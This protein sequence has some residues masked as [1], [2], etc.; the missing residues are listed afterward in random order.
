MADF[1]AEFQERPDKAARPISPI[2]LALTEGRALTSIREITFG[3]FSS[4]SDQSSSSSEVNYCDENEVGKGKAY[5]S[6]DNA[7]SDSVIVK[8]NEFEGHT[9]HNVI[10]NVAN[11][12]DERLV[13]KNGTSSKPSKKEG[14]ALPEGDRNVGGNRARAVD[15]LSKDVVSVGGNDNFDGKIIVSIF[16]SNLKDNF[17]KRKNFPYLKKIIRKCSLLRSLILKLVLIHISR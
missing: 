12:K 17:N 13:T 6:K 15:E 16:P 3:E 7:N 5:S 4:E 14:H 1:N 8:R 11:S 9:T 10:S 2:T